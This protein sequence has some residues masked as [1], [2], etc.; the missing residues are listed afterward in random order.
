MKVGKMSVLILI[1]ISVTLGVFGQIS[2]KKGMNSVGRM[3]LKDLITS[4]IFSLVREKFVILGVILYV[5]ATFIWLVILSQEEVSFAYPLI[6]MGYIFV[7]ILGKILFNENLT[8][9]RMLGIILIVIGVYLI[10][11]KI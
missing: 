8:F 1:L 9:F 3:E 10:S 7:A 4:K 2:L 6:A 11:S 5:S